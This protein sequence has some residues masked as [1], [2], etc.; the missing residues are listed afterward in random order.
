LILL[1]IQ[2]IPSKHLVMA[3]LM[4]WEGVV[5][6]TGYVMTY[7]RAR[8]LPNSER[9]VPW[10]SMADCAGILTAGLASV[11]IEWKNGVDKLIY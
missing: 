5:G 3:V 8:Q 4:V 1:K 7:S 2:F 10:V 11:L 6:G 9:L